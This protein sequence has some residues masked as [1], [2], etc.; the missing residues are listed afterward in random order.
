MRTRPLPPPITIR[1]AV[2]A[3][4]IPAW[5]RAVVTVARRLAAERAH[6]GK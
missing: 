3:G 1:P 5:A 2:Q 6:A 4:D